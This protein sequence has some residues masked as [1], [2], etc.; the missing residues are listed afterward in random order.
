MSP[1]DYIAQRI[2]GQV[3]WYGERSRAAQYRFKALRIVEIVSAALIPLLAGFLPAIPY[4]S[5][6]VAILGVLVAVSAGLIGIGHYQELWL[7]YR[8]TS[9]S[10]KNQKYLFLTRSMP[11]DNDQA[12]ALLVQGVETLIASGNRQWS[13]QVRVPARA[14]PPTGDAQHA[15]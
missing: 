9:E 8:M 15:E 13:Q 2:D 6:V 14:S 7:Q 11:Y 10:L 5:L 1:E 3:A 12:F 4:G